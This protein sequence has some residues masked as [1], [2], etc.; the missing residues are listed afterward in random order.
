MKK[1]DSIKRFDR[2]R[3]TKHIKSWK[4]NSFTQNVKKPVLIKKG[5]PIELHKRSGNLELVIDCVTESD[6]NK[7]ETVLINCANLRKKYL[8]QIISETKSCME[9]KFMK[10]FNSGRSS[11]NMYFF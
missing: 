8:G 6:A 2:I 9:K 1:L 4:G 10:N 7:G 11:K 5:Q 3:N